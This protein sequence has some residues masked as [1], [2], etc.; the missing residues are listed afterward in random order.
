MPPVTTT[1]CAEG[2]VKTQLSACLK[3]KVPGGP[4]GG[5]AQKSAPENC[6]CVRHA[7]CRVASAPQAAAALMRRSCTDRAASR[8]SNR[9]NCP[10]HTC[11]SLYHGTSHLP[12]SWS[13]R[14]ISFPWPLTT[15]GG[16]SQDRPPPST[17]EPA[18]HAHGCASHTRLRCRQ[19]GASPARLSM[20]STPGT[21]ERLPAAPPACGVGMKAD[22][23]LRRAAWPLRA[24]VGSAIRLA[25]THRVRAACDPRPPRPAAPLCAAP[26]ATAAQTADLPRAI[27]PVSTARAAAARG[28]TRP[29]CGPAPGVARRSALARV[30]SPAPSGPRAAHVPSRQPEAAGAT[31][32]TARARRPCAHARR[33]LPARPPSSPGPCPPAPPPRT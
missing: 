31:P 30:A 21:R 1:Y 17:R 22:L 7:K 10:G 33:T 23:H 2:Q 28:A 12:R 24:Q 8:V 20:P 5:S 13:A 6:V 16:R 32:A 4:H 25:F 29:R 15:C 14:Q 11:G 9:P 18:A 26:R 19:A 3:R 27:A